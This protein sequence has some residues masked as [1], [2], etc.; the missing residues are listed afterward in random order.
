MYMQNLKQ[1]SAFTS[2][3]N[4]QAEEEN[5]ATQVA[6]QSGLVRAIHSNHAWVPFSLCRS[7]YHYVFV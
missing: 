6:T 7:D 2:S 4:A 3:D 1:I 5:D